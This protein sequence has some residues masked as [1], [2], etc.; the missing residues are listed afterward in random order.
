M[1]LPHLGHHDQPE[2]QPTTP[3][4]PPER[5]LTRDELVELSSFFAAP[6]WLR[7]L[8]LASWFLVGAL[9]VIGGLTLLLAATSEIVDPMIGAAIVAV[10][11][12]PLVGAMSRHRIP[13]A[14]GAAIVLL[15]VVAICIAIVVIVIGGLTS[16][17]DSIS[18]EASSA[19]DTVQTWLQGLGVDESGATGANE[20]VSSAVPQI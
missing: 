11:T 5:G 19:A 3:L 20:N 13:R 18:A 1:K 4:P 7:D 12:S 9:L 16:Q 2:E 14:L 17:G 6:R 15:G 10:V 8:G